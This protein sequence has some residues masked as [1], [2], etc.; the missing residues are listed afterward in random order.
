MGFWF[1][2]NSLWCKSGIYFFISFAAV[3]VT[4]GLAAASIATGGFAG[5]LI[6]RITRQ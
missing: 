1:R 6:D 5:G 2:N 3:F 4:G